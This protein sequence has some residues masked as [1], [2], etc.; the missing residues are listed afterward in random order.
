MVRMENFYPDHPNILLFSVFLILHFMRFSNTLTYNY[1]S[2]N[3]PKKT[4][5]IPHVIAK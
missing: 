5:T 3:L 4:A 2:M 1:L